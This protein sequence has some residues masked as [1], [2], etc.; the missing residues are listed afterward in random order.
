MKR[1][2]LILALV[3]CFGLSVHAFAQEST[4][5]TPRWA[6]VLTSKAASDLVKKS[7]DLGATWTV[8]GNTTVMI[9]GRAFLDQALVKKL[10]GQQ[11]SIEPAIRI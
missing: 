6:V 9:G 3:C 8:F 5:D 11:F 2:A 4:S 7:P 1:I 10:D